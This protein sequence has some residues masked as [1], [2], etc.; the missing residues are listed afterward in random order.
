MLK[1]L[2]CII[3]AEWNRNG[4]ANKNSV[5]RENTDGA[6]GSTQRN[7][8]KLQNCQDFFHI[9]VSIVFCK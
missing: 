5:A 8:I 4:K 3:H 1:L 2:P 6:D 9:A 7:R